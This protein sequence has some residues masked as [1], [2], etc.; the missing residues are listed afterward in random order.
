[1]PLVG[2]LVKIF[3]A[4]IVIIIVVV[5]IW[6]FFFRGDSTDNFIEFDDCDRSVRP[7]WWY[8]HMSDNLYFTP[9][10]AYNKIFYDG[11]PHDAHRYYKRKFGGSRHPARHGPHHGKLR[12]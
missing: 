8:A 9:T 6:F 1:M 3:I 2:L 5:G 10:Y 4:I 11:R 12:N 7:W